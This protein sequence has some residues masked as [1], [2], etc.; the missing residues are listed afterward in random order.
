[1]N[2]TLER[3]ALIVNS[4]I[5]IIRNYIR[6]L[7]NPDIFRTIRAFSKIKIINLLSLV[8]ILY[9]RILGNI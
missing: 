8:Q 2:I 3:S 1:M 7:K 5:E 9:L 6:R 4:K